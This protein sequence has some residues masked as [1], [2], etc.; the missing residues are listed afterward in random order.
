[1]KD[2]DWCWV[3][4]KDEIGEYKTMVNDDDTWWVT[5]TWDQSCW[6]FYKLSTSSF[7]LLQLPTELWCTAP[8]HRSD[9]TWARATMELVVWVWTEPQQVENEWRWNESTVVLFCSQ[10]PGH[11]YVEIIGPSGYPDAILSGLVSSIFW[12]ASHFSFAER[13]LQCDFI[14]SLPVLQPNFNNAMHLDHDAATLQTAYFLF[15][16]NTLQA[17]SSRGLAEWKLW[18]LQRHNSFHL[19]KPNGFYLPLLS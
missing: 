2:D 19:R 15:P 17:F 1:M 4:M 5:I 6:W 8:A 18:K 11:Q 14:T 9:S 10:Q 16:T 7:L 3:I 12:Y 13:K